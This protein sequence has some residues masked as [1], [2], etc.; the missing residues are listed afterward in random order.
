MDLCGSRAGSRDGRLDRVGSSGSDHRARRRCEYSPHRLA[1]AEP[2]SQGI[3]GCGFKQ[4]L[5]NYESQGIQYHA[6]RTRQAGTRAFISLHVL[7]PREWTVQRGHDLLEQMERD[8]RSAIP[9][10]QLITHLEPQDDP[11]AWEDIALER[12]DSATGSQNN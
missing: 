1:I 12:K 6:L 9:G 3:D 7:V 10:A 2:L 8:L 4:V 5:N 11:A